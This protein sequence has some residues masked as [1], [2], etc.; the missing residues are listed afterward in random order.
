MANACRRTVHSLALDRGLFLCF[1]FLLLLVFFFVLFTL[2]IKNVFHF[3]DSLNEEGIEEK[4][5][6]KEYQ[7]ALA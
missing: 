6:D 2:L 5:E 1:F 4:L 3:D 7:P